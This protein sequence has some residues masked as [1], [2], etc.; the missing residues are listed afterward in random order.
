MK[1]AQ[2]VFAVALGVALL[3]MTNVYAQTGG[4]TMGGQ[5]GGAAEAGASSPIWGREVGGPGAQKMGGMMKDMAGRMTSMAGHMAEG[6]L[7]AA[8]QKQMAERLR[9]MATM[10]DRMSGMA[11]KGMM[12]DADMDKQMD[13]MRKQMD[14]TM[15]HPDGPSHHG[16]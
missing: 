4:G 7:S 10:L 3:G 15:P 8:E 14:D 6:K 13:Q 9:T 11:G 2:R 5:K 12:T 1:Q 16:L